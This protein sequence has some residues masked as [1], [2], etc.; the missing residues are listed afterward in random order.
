VPYQ[1]FETADGRVVIAV[2]NDRQFAKLMAM[3]GLDALA[4]DPRFATNGARVVNRDAL[5]AQLVE[6]VRA[7]TTAFWLDALA[8]AGVPGGPVRSVQE[9]L[10]APETVARGMV[11]HV[12]HP[13]AGALDLIGSPI[14]M[15]ETPVVDPVAP[16]LLGADSASVLGGMLGYSDNEISAAAGART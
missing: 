6:P 7:H 9:A 12:D 13:T 5:I 10:T 4:R 11:R 3:I 15:L 1:T 2:G 16:P 8:K 14:R